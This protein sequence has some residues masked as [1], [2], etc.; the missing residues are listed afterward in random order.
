MCQKL[1]FFVDG[2]ERRRRINARLGAVQVDDAP[3]SDEE[4]KGDHRRLKQ[5]ARPAVLVDEC[6]GSLHRLVHHQLKARSELRPLNGARCVQ[7]FYCEGR[8]REKMMK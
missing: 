6:T 8:E 1:L 4:Q 5:V 7:D 3:V 2:R